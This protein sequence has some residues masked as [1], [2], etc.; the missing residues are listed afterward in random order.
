MAL[1]FFTIPIR[2]V[3]QGETELNG[4]LSSHRVLAVD[5]QFVNL[6]ENSFWAL[7]VDYL[8]SSSSDSGASSQAAGRKGRID[9]REELS[10]QAFAVFA[11]LRDL[12]KQLA[13]AEAVPVYTIFTNDQLA[14][15]VRRNVASKADLEAIAGVGD[16]RVGKYG[17]QFLAALQ[18]AGGNRETSGLPA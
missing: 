9:Y 14:E 16:A 2:D 15:M 3:A 11:K 18:A 12:R 7:C 17:P 6:G 13:Q 4:F 1:K 5:R 8:P 10:P